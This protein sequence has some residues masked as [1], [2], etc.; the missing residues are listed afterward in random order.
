MT[1]AYFDCF[2]GVAGDMILGAL[3]DLGVDIIVFEK[4]AEKTSSHRVRH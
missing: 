3:I 1:I 2:S 4:R